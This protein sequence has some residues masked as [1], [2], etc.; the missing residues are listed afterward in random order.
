L[1]WR[2]SHGSAITVRLPSGTPVRLG[3]V[4]DADTMRDVAYIVPGCGDD[5]GRLHAAMI[6]AVPEL[7]AVAEAV[8]ASRDDATELA[9]EALA[10]A[11]SDSGKNLLQGWGGDCVR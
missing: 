2:T 6:A 3:I 11:A 8:V 9:Q 4:W 7:L 10:K 5:S 1:T